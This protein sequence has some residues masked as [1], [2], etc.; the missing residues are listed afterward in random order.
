[1]SKSLSKREANRARYRNQRLTSTLIWG[2]LGVGVL[3]LLGFF[4]WQGVRPGSARG[5]EVQVPADYTHIEIGTPPGPYISDPPAGGRHYPTTFKAGFYEESDVASLSQYPEGYLVHNQEHGYVIFWYNCP[6]PGVSDCESLKADIRKVMDGFG[7]VKLIAFP[8]KSLDV[9]VIMTS[10]GRM[11]RLEV[12]ETTEAS[13][14][15]RANRNHSPEPN[16]P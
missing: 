5:V 16:A 1:M 3:A 7:G 15:I 11:E 9:P 8:W 12:F 14:F 10:W 2:S 13:A 6:A 4:V